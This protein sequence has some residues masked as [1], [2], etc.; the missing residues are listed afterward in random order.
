MHGTAV[1]KLIVTEIVCVGD[2]LQNPWQCHAKIG[3]WAD[4]FSLPN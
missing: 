4:H 3:P 1:R 2:L